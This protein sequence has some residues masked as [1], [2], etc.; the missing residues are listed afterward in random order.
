M[1]ETED[2][3][4]ISNEKLLFD[5]LETENEV[6]AYR[7]LSEGYNTLA[8][9][10]DQSEHNRTMMSFRAGGYENSRRQCQAFLDK[11]IALKAER[12]L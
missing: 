5:I 12:G 1:I 7:K 6:E 11:L 3:K 8:R 10:S 4:K 2:S 9:L